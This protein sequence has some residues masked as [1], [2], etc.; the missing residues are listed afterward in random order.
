MAQEH[1]R[2]VAAE[3]VERERHAVGRRAPCAAG[4]AGEP[5]AHAGSGGRRRPNPAGRDRRPA[6]VPVGSAADARGRGHRG[7]ARGQ[8]RLLRRLRGAATS[9]PCP[10]SG[11]TTTTSCAPTRGGRRCT[12]GGRW[13]ARGS[14]CSAG[15]QHLQFILTDERVH[16][17]GR[18]GVG[19]G[20]REPDRRA[21]RAP[22][23]RR[24]TCSGGSTAAGA[25]SCTTARR[26]LPPRPSNLQV[27]CKNP[28]CP[29]TGGP[30]GRPAPAMPSSMPASPSS[31]RA[32]CA[33]PR[34]ASPSGP[35]CR[36]GRCSSTSTTCR[37][38][39]P[40]SS[41]RVVERL[42]VLVVPVDP[43]LPLDR[44]IADFARHRADLLEAVTP[45]RRA[46]AVHGPFSPELR[47]ASPRERLP[48]RARS[49]RRSLPSS[50]AAPRRDRRE[51]LD[52]LAVA[53]SWGAWD[54][55][56]AEAGD[57][58]TRPGPCSAAC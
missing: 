56:R 20:R 47:E 39:T 10:T 14:P 22:R 29:P 24:S 34:R 45:F 13:R 16:G 43:T 12:G 28:P 35:A 54:A 42:A 3:V 7:R 21:G 23:W 57:T 19:D 36:C 8:P 51:L 32:T 4:G 46:A 5:S 31:R 18:D 37:R 26:W 2:P 1:R 15:P 40:R 49:R 30:P 9:T 52:A 38:C 58:P 27:P 41:H 11:T 25:W 17:L 44:R 6:A 50:T 33:P 48:A 55:L 53:T